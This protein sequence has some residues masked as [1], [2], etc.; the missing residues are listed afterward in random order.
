MSEAKHDAMSEPVKP[1]R[2]R[3]KSIGR[4]LQQALTAAQE[5]DNE[6]TN[7]MSIAR[8]K[9]LQARLNVLAQMQARERRDGLKIVREQLATAANVNARLAAELAT[10]R[11]EIERLTGQIAQTQHGKSH[12]DNLDAKFKQIDTEYGSQQM[13]G[14]N[15]V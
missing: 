3:R 14:E 10:A 4:Q 6:P 12:F 5:L 13:K 1:K 2:H 11:T 7:D 9:F 8:M 15:N